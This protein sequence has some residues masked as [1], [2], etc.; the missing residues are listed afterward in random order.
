MTKS[1]P[2]FRYF[3]CPECD[4]DKEIQPKD[5]PLHLK[6]VHNIIETKGHKSLLM[7]VNKEPRHAASF[8]W[9]IGGKTFYEY[10]G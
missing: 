6:D 1:Y 7:H 8:E 5:F 9:T 4:K 3:I 2:P 10:Y